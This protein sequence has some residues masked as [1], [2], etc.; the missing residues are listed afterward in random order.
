MKVKLLD[1]F[2]TFA[3]VGC[4]IFGGGVVIIPL[5]EKE[6]IQKKGWLTMEEL[7]EFYA[8]SQVIPGINIPDVSMFIGYKLRGKSGAII[9]GLGVIFVPFIL[10]VLVSLFLSLISNNSI[11]EGALW[12]LSIGTI[13]VLVS[14]V[15]NIWKHSIVDIFTLTLFLFVLILMTFTK[16]SP[17]WIVVFALLLGILKGF[18]TQNKEKAE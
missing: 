6:A 5:L 12:G 15:R 7:V 17:V 1:I 14:A 13:V 16:I 9:A 3:K 11:V 8:I 2:L 10:I 4:L 18:L